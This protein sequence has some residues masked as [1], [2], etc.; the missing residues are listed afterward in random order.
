MLVKKIL[1]V[2]SGAVGS[3]YGSLFL[4]A[5]HNVT[6]LAKGK[7]LE[8]LKNEGLKVDSY[9]FGQYS[10][11]VDVTD[12]AQGSFDYLI[13]CV[14]S[15]D[16]YSACEQVKNN[17]HENS[18][19][20]SFQNGVE[21]VEILSEFF[22]AEKIIGASVFIGA[23]IEESGKLIHSA[24]GIVTFGAILKNNK[25]VVDNFEELLKS[26][27]IEFA[28][29]YFILPAMWKKLLWNIAFNP[30][31]TIL[32][33]TCGR[34]LKDKKIIEMMYELLS[35]G[36]E[37]A[38]TDGIIID[39]SY[40]KNVPN[41]SKGLEN[42]KTSMLQ[43]IEKGKKPEIDGILGPVIRKLNKVGKKAPYSDSLY[44]LISFKYGRT[45]LYTP[46]LTVD[47]IAV[48]DNKILLI[49]RKNP[50]YGWALPGGFV[51]YGETVENAARREL[52]EETNI[53]ANDLTMLGVYSDPKR[54]NRMHTVSVVYFTYT[55]KEPKAADDAKNANFFTFDDLPSEIAFDHRQII[56]DYLERIS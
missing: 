23:A 12:K 28:K 17:V 43:D 14:K 46:K 42:F 35:E 50:P 30:L 45:F 27:E 4:R 51:D 18:I 7:R 40:W 32:E 16:T 39:E 36:V 44:K 5:G 9:K 38:K 55:D 25:Q 33:T 8:S 31:S 3:F 22:G 41:M 47:V 37:A 48:K 20:V 19:F 34:M 6:F 53:A 21:N 11:K 52:M 13:F 56:N 29:E 2:G 49:E 26:T 15:H 1:I 10:L 24:H 54:D